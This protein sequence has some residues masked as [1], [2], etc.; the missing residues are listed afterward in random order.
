MSEE[1]VLH[2]EYFKILHTITKVQCS[3][4][5]DKFSGVFLPFPK[6]GHKEHSPRVMLIGR[7]TGGWNTDNKKNTLQRIV[8]KNERGN[9]EDIIQEAKARY[10]LHLRNLTKKTRSH[11]M[12]FH[13]SLEDELGHQVFYTNLFAWDYNKKSPL[14]APSEQDIGMVKSLSVQLLAVQFHYFKPDFVIFATGCYGV[15]KVIKH[16]VDSK[17]GGFSR[18]KVVYSKR[19]WNF[20]VNDHP[21]TIFYRINHPRSTDKKNVKMEENSFHMIREFVTSKMKESEQTCHG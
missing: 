18:S 13:K 8:D 9:L 15:D 2:E 6:E 19:L 16:F 21:D 3:K 5:D 7:E 4:G 14:I 11:F 10:E 1:K 12:R 20:Q 17:L